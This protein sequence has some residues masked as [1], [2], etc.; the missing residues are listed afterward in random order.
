MKRP[1][2]EAFARNLSP[3]TTASVRSASVQK[4]KARKEILWDDLKDVEAARTEAARIKDDVLDRLKPLLLQFETAA[5]ALG[6]QVHWCVDGESARAKILEIC[7][8]TEPQG[9]VVVKAK[10][11][12][13]EEIHLNDYLEE[14]GFTPVETDLGEFVVQVDHD[15]PSHIVTPIIH[16]NRRQIAAS[17]AREDLGPYSEVPEELAMQARLHLRQ[18]FESA[19]IG[20]SGVNFAIAETGRIVLVENEGNNRLSTTAVETHIAVMGIE[21]L[22][23]RESDLPL[24]LRLLAG[25]ATGQRLTSY[26]HF[27]AGP[28]RSDE[29]DGPREVH[30]IL[31]DN[32]RTRVLAGKYREIL[33]CIRCGACLNVCPVYRQASGHAYGHVYSGP[34]GAVLAPALEGIEKL[35]ELAKASSLCGACEEVCPVK[36]P[37]PR[38]LLELRDEA[39]Q[40][41]VI[42]EVIPW[43][44]FAA[45]ATQPAGWRMGLKLLPMA[46]FAPGGPAKQGWTE[47]RELPEIE[48]RNFRKW[49]N[50]R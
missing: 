21:K 44:A 49:W 7:R 48:G 3:E 43:K 4:T 31:L 5:T 46:K 23:A 36:I 24:F 35:G 6:V 13:T 18:K 16:K 39:T 1:K 11:M 50:S 9:G 12:A 40:A 37:I 29:E 14:H 22:L 34:L 41:G 47:S 20:I 28:R 30:V 2:V 19:K 15:T 25:S 32:G 33:R 27:I 26:T 10:S 17:F 8:Q 38:M 42:K 45:G